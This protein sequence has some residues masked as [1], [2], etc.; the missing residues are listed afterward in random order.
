M[1]EHYGIDEDEY[2]RM[3]KTQ[4]G[5]CKIC[6]HPKKTRN[7]AVDHKHQLNFKKMKNSEKRKYLRGILC[8]KCNKGLE[9]FNDNPQHL[10][11][12]SQYLIDWQEKFNQKER[13]K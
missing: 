8:W 13:E 4:G 5:V 6:G 7:L 12:A 2:N 10:Q 3:L 11:N 9:L 1:L